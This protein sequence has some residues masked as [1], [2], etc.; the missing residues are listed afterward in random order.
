SLRKN[1]R[2][3]YYRLGMAYYLRGDYAEAA[4]AYK[5]CLANSSDDALKV[6]CD[7]WLYPS[8]RRSG[9]EADAARLLAQLQIST[10]PGHPGYY[11]DRLLLFKGVKTE[12]EVAKT[13][14]SE[15]A[16]S[17]ATVGYGIGLWHLLNGRR[18]LAREWFQR[19][20]ASGFTLGW[21][22]RASEAELRTLR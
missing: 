7:A 1:D 6:E 16:L 22:Y 10:L 2:G 20:V 4:N 13:T 18:D 8:L 12:E 15:G 21:G 11:L 14:A 9:D 19:S 17:E 3:I 5:G